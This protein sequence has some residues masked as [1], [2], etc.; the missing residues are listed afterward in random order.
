MIYDSSINLVNSDVKWRHRHSY[1]SAVLRESGYD[2][3]FARCLLEFFESQK[4]PGKISNFLGVCSFLY[5]NSQ[6]DI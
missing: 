4:G 2:F 3:P 6:S 5:F 1:A